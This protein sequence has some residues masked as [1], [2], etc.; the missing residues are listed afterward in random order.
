VLAVL[1]LV[2][3]MLVGCG[4]GGDDNIS[5][6]DVQQAAAAAVKKAQQQ[7]KLKDL[8]KQVNELKKSQSGET[9]AT[10]PSS[11][12]SGGSTDCGNGISVNSNTSCAFAQYV[13]EGYRA[14]GD[15]VIRAYS[16]VTD[17]TYAMTCSGS[18]P[19][20]CRGGNDAAVY[21]SP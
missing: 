16:P 14:T 3:A 7:Q 15:S 21:I 17:D 18:N 6:Q 19:T 13:A 11:S 10:G 12:S 1:G 8:E 20:V 2:S 5:S 9:A 4:G